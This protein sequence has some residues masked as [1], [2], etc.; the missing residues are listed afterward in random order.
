VPAGN[1]CRAT[2]ASPH[3][4][5]EPS[6][7]SSF[8]RFKDRLIWPHPTIRYD[9]MLVVA[10]AITAAAKA[11]RPINRHVVRAAI[12]SAHVQTLQG[13]IAFDANGDLLNKAVSAFQI[14]Y[15]AKYAAD[16]VQHQYVYVGAAPA[17]TV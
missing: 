17:E 9:A 6:V 8:R 3:V 5:D 11:G 16:D 15:D 14:R 1:F 13:A 4:V 12:Q 10:A 2:L 7:Q